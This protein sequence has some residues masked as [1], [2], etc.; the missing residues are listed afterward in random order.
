MNYLIFVFT[1]IFLNEQLQ[2]QIEISA[3]AYSSASYEASSNDQ[4]ISYTLGETIIYGG[5]N[6]NFSACQ[7]FQSG[8][9]NATVSTIETEAGIIN[10]TYYPNPTSDEMNITWPINNI[11]T[12]IM[13]LD[14]KGSLVENYNIDSKIENTLTIN[15]SEYFNGLYYIYVKTN[16][17]QLIHAGDFIHLK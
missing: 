4:H 7:G 15:V 9:E 6:G 1:F 17:K 12:G 3:Q 11:L 16:N 2:A 10:I 5:N 13:I 14:S 8:I